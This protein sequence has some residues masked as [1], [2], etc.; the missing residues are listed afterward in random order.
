MSY[1]INESAVSD[2]HSEHYTEGMRSA[3]ITLDFVH[4]IRSCNLQNLF[5]N[6]TFQFFLK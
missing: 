2:F 3:F 1:L 5:C 6:Q 4:S